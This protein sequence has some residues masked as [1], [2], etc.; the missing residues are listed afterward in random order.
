MKLTTV[1]QLQP[2]NGQRQLLYDTL[3]QANSAC[4]Y[5]SDVAWA[6]KCFGRVPVH[7]L[8]YGEVRERFGLGAQMAVRCIGKVTDAYKTDKQTKRVFR[9]LGAIAYDN[10]ILNYRLDDRTVS[11]WLLGG[12][13]E[14]PF[15]CGAL[16]FELL[17][18]QQGESD[19]VHRK[20]KFYLLAT[21]DV[22]DEVP[23]DPE[24]FL[25]VDLGVVNIATD[26]DGEHWSGS[27]INNVRVRYSKLRTKLQKK[28]TKSAKRLLKKRA[29]R[30]K[31]FRNDVNHCLSKQLVGKAKGTGRGIALED[32]E[33][34]RDRITVRRPQRLLLHSWAFHD[35]R[36]K[37]TYKG[38]LHGVPVV[39]VDPRN[40]SR[41]C[42]VCG[43][44]DKASRVS[45]SKFLC[46]SCGYA[47]HA[48]V[49]AACNIASRAA[50]NPPDAG[51]EQ[52]LNPA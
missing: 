30:E 19:L 36:T 10:R 11:I 22:P 8:T 3:A 12:R 44:I 27:H 37:I 28:G 5:I 29:G 38:R 42:S 40:T 13:Q 20:G 51:S 24:G 6:E 25:G 45:Q 43:H 1:V 34:I 17:K 9:K 32:L 33:G 26:S 21:C 41:Q 4:N 47:A 49:N 35:L 16:Q 7:K 52:G 39:L 18:H 48:D 23:L 15:V 31:R 14:M 46:T 50:V 2:D